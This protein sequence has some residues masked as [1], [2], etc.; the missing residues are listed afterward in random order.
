MLVVLGLFQGYVLLA[1]NPAPVKT[2]ELHPILRMSVA[3][4]VLVDED[5]LIT[6]LLRPPSDDEDMGVPVAP[7]SLDYR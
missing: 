2:A 6:D 7:R 4:L 1:P 5:L 3:T